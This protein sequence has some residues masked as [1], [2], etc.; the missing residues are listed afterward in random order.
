LLALAVAA[1]QDSPPTVTVIAQNLNNPRGVAIYPDGRLLLAEAG[2]GLPDSYS[3]RISI[4]EDINGDGD[5]DDS[6]E[7]TPLLDGLP[8]YNAYTLFNP[9]RD[10]VLGV[11]DVILLDDGRIIYTIDDKFET[12]QILEYDPASG[13]SRRIIDGVGTLNSL[14]YDPS[15]AL[16]F[17]AESSL[18]MVTTITLDGERS[19][20]VI[21]P[22]L[23]SGQQAVPA[24]LALDPLT[25]D[26]L[27]ALFSGNLF[28]Y[29]GTVLNYMP[30]D[31]KIVRVDPDTGE[32]TDEITGLTT[33]VDVAVD[34][35]GRVFALEMSTRWPPP[36]LFRPFDLYDPASP[37]DDGG[38]GRFQG[39]VSMLL[40]DDLIRLADGLDAPTNITVQGGV[41]YVSTGQGTPGRLIFG[42]DGRT[43]ITGQIIQITGYE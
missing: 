4:F 41:L 31:A 37:P 29:Y 21:F 26:L 25:G 40:G 12:I 20:L 35:T 30:G 5:Y 13:N 9:G 6:G 43:P 17:V 11:G 32:F 27:V 34:E 19:A 3:G 7:Q 15:R 22:P 36:P 10:E 14:V 39:R 28:D 23:H 24:G 16:L 42:D 2:T 33:A 38:Y 8:S 1:V 18:N